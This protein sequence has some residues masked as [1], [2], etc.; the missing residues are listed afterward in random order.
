MEAALALAIK[1]DR[2]RQI[3]DREPQTPNELWA[4]EVITL[5][6]RAPSNLLPPKD[7]K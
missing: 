2:D 1:I 3:Q 6:A 7:Q 4:D 5:L